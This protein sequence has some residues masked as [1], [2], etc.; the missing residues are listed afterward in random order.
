M[1]PT[2]RGGADR[3]VLEI[4]S[5]A[6]KDRLLTAGDRVAAMGAAPGLRRGDVVRATVE[7]APVQLFAN[8]EV[9]NRLAGVE[10]DHVAA[11]GKLRAVEVVSRGFGI[12]SLVD[13]A[14]AR[15]RERI[16]ATYHP[17][18]A[19]LA[20]ALVLGETDLDPSVDEAFRETG[21]SHLLAVSGT[22]LVVA[23]LSLAAA[24]RAILLRVPLVSARFSV[25]RISSALA[26]PLAWAYSDFAGGSGS[27]LRAAAMLTVA[28]GARTLGRAPCA[29]RSV[30][31][32]IA[33]GVVLDPLALLDVSFTLSTAATV[34]LLV[35]SRPL[36]RALG[37]EAPEGAGLLRR[38]WSKLA[39]AIGAT[40]A[41]TLACAPAILTLS[42]RLPL[43]GLAANLVAAPLGELFALP[44]CLAHGV[45]SAFPPVELGAARVGSG[46][47][48]GVLGIARVANAIPLRL[49]VPTPTGG[50]IG[51][52]A[53]GA[54]VIATRSSWRSRAMA[55]ALVA[56]SIGALEIGTRYEAQP[57]GK[58]RVSA[59]DI[60]QGDSLLVDLP[61]GGAMLIDAGGIPASA[62]DTGK[63][64]V[65]PVLRARRR[66][67]LD[68]VVL[69]HP[70][71]DHF[72]GLTSTLQETEV[73]EIWDTGEA[74]RGDGGYAARKILD[75][76]R[77]RGTPILRPAD[78]CGA[79]RDVGG[80]TVRVLA[81][82]P[83]LQEGWS[84]NDG[85]LVLKITFG[86]RSALF[87]G[88]AEHAA[89]ERL[90]ATEYDNL[91]ADLL[92][93]GHHGSKTSS[94]PTFIAR[95]APR[96]A[97]ISCGVRNRFGHPSRSTLD[98]LAEEGTVVR[99]TDLG[100]EWRWWTDGEEVWTSR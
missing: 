91:P 12:E 61:S 3:V 10:R 15:V 68:V 49:A 9:S 39:E 36:G 26:I 41:A 45:L 22:H 95:V 52:L 79:P 70:H 28:L 77:A 55:M 40:L 73:G 65:L 35:L 34:G 37:S 90:L 11:T 38:A 88:D 89:E 47:L 85:S 93:V 92:K 60:G 19:P 84:T 29:S 17:D 8:D 74:E 33:T 43:V 18:A 75:A 21:L 66:S 82:C 1:S 86:H 100:G 87:V 20:R 23:V 64:V 96:W 32:A 67:R 81:P 98:T 30:G 57:V 83:D 48:L 13:D 76:A 42:P 27:V 69:S 54:I 97:V 62:L 6:C 56:A 24:L 71:P 25:D 80:A 4:A 53:L 16:D 72:G 2:V 58:L 59:L 94:S 44:I 14:R 51:V 7:L 31:L 46:A 5:G 50:E 63:R 78:L 99:R